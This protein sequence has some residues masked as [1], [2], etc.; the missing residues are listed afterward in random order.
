[1]VWIGT[2]AAGHYHQLPPVLKLDDVKAGYTATSGAWLGAYLLFMQTVAC[3]NGYEKNFLMLSETQWQC[4]VCNKDLCLLSSSTMLLCTGLCCLMGRIWQL[5]HA[6]NL[7]WQSTGVSN[8]RCPGLDS[9]GMLVFP[10]FPPH[11]INFICFIQCNVDSS[12]YRWPVNK[13]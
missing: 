11:K 13:I 3:I 6:M 8:Q 7:V 10:L 2:A 12:S 1:M 5:Q 4:R 9:Q